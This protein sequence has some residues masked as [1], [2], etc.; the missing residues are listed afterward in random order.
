M[1]YRRINRKLNSAHQDTPIR[2]VKNSIITDNI[3]KAQAFNSY[4]AS[5]FNAKP[6]SPRS[7]TIDN[8]KTTHLSVETDFSPNNVFCTLKNTKHSFSS[9]PDSIPLAFWTNVADTVAFRVSIIFSLSYQHAVLPDDWKNAIVL[10]LFKKGDPSLVCNYRPISLTFTLCKVMETII[11][12]NLYEFGFKYNIIS[13]SQHYFLPG[14]SICTQL[15]ECN[16]DW[17]RAL[18]ADDKVDVMFMDLQKAF[19]VV[20]HDKLIAKLEAFG[21][22]CKTLRWIRAF[23]K[24]RKQTVRLN[25]KLSNSNSVV[26]GVVQG[27]I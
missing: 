11:K 6:S 12:N 10:P 18:D 1:F 20:P 8:Y 27:S 7:V 16:Y 15:L 23:L 5:V 3:S 25:G 4:F 9:G 22:C 19:N 26:S 24:D 2:E 21:I 14:R 17:C 13:T